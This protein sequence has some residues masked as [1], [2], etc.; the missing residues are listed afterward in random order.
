[1]ALF[2]LGWRLIIDYEVCLCG[3]LTALASPTPVASFKSE[4]YSCVEQGYTVYWFSKRVTDIKV[5]AKEPGVSCG[6]CAG[7]FRISLHNME[8]HHL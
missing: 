7:L 5:A 6:M 4:Q 8:H 1:M 3:R 2:R